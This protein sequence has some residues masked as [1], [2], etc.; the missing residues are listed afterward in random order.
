MNI[1]ERYSTAK[2]TS[3]LTV[4]TLTNSSASDILAASGMASQ[5]APEAMALWE[6]A[7]SGKAGSKRALVDIMASNLAGKMIKN[8]WKGDPKKIAQEVIA[9]YFHGTCQP[10]GG[11][12]YQL[13]KGSPVLDETKVCPHCHGT[14]KV[15]LPRN[16]A[17][18][19][20]SSNIDKLLSSAGGHVAKKLARN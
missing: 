14:G 9:W 8:R 15:S 4:S 2:N 13:I 1:Q 18:Q 11:R 5:E 7:F 16:D 19:W 20:L 12:K 17:H 6:S 3:D 10:C